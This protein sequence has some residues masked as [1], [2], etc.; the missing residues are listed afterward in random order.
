MRYTGGKGNLY[1]KI[2]NLIPPH[3]VYIETHL[4]GGAV[5]RYKKPAKTNIGI[6]LDGKV[7]AGRR[8]DIGIPGCIVI[9][10]DA[11]RFLCEYKFTGNEFVYCDPPYLMETRRGGKIYKH[12]Y[13][14]EQHLELIQIL[15]SL[16]C[17][18]MISGYPN[19]IY[20][21]VVPMW[22]RKEFKVKTRAGTD[23]TECLWM[24]YSEPLQL[25]DYSFLGETFRER[26]RINRKT[27]RWLARLH[28][29]KPLEVLA[30][31]DALGQ[32]RPK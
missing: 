28:K 30:M 25:H 9:Q 20:D 31:A 16:E 12:E 3:D 19:A 2:I 4:G 5:L 11:G 27:A 21:D 24:N 1:R 22:K 17:K 13:T 7:V 10:G 6:D 26:E 32:Y 14:T 8:K 15:K 18:I 29:M 23:A